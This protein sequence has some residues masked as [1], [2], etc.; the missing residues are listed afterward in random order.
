MNKIILLGRL[1]KDPDMRVA[2]NQVSVCRYSLAVDRKYKKND[3]IATDFFNIVCFGKAAEFA[4]KYFTKGLKV[5]ITGTVQ[6]N[7]YK[8]KDVVKVYEVQVVAEEQEFA[9]SKK[10]GSNDGF[11]NAD[12]AILEGELPFV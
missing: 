9:E 11:V 2:Q 3:E 12:S 6:N 7:N 4:S 10:S 8:N 1:T 5:L